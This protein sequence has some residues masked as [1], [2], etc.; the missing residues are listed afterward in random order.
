MTENA[1]PRDPREP[2]D[3]GPL[4]ARANLLRMRGRWAE[5][6]EECAA[7]LRQDPA[8]GTAC[9]LL[10]DIHQDQGRAEEARHWYHLALELNPGS[11]ADRAKLSR[12][13]EALEAR[14]RRAEWSAVIEGR[15]PPAETALLVRES[16][17]R[18]GAIAGAALC[19]MI[20]VM[21][22]LVSVAERRGGPGDDPGAPLFARG[23]R[24]AVAA[25]P[26]TYRERAL[27]R[28]IKDVAG[29][30]PGIA[31]RVELDPRGN[32]A[33]L[34]VF[35]PR[36]GREG[37][38][39]ADAGELALR[40]AYRLAR[41]LRDAAADLREHEDS[42]QLIHVFVVGP[43]HAAYSTGDTELLLIGV[44]ARQDLVVAPDVVTGE[45]LATFFGRTAPPR[46]FGDLA[47]L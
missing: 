43:S 37:L 27:L 26:D 11:E 13:E 40:E 14:S 47:G 45:E 1:P 38:T 16:L 15:S 3:S 42:L 18:I 8:N 24:P 32:A 44:I 30:G 9:S 46:W 20:L 36:R 7:A 17:Q 5:A 29:N 2:A 10:G 25:N 35:L 31:A 41:A 19:G 6:A 39:A 23:S 4:L 12:A 28:R 22:T 33:T 21:A 34:R